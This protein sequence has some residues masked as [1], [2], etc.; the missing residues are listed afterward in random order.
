MGIEGKK[1]NVIMP[2]VSW[3]QMLNYYINSPQ[4]LEDTYGFYN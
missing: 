4:L 2:E 1:D 3:F